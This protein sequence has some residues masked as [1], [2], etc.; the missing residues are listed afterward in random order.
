LISRLG[1]AIKHRSATKGA[2]TERGGGTCAHVHFGAGK[3]KGKK[4]ENLHGGVW[5]KDR[6]GA[7]TLPN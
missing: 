2:T 4:K 6:R 5:N 3:R 1:N 7:T